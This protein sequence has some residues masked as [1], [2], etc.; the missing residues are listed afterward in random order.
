VLKPNDRVIWFKR[1]GRWACGK[2]PATVVALKGKTQAVIKLEN[3][4]TKTVSI[5]NL[6]IIK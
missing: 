3:G 4:E 5:E 2:F 1:E 6:E